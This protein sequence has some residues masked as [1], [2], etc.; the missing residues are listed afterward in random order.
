MS[1]AEDFAGIAPFFEVTPA[2]RRGPLVYNSPHSGSHYPERFLAMIRLDR[3]GIR[4]VSVLTALTMLATL[5][6]D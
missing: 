1:A 6:E 3:D 5:I 4:R 2:V